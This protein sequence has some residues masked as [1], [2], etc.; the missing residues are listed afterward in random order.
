MFSKLLSCYTRSVSLGLSAKDLSANL[1]A[2]VL[3]S[4]EVCFLK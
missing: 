4:L 1:G 2:C 3:A